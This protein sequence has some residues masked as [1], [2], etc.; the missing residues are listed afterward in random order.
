M[1]ALDQRAVR[2]QDEHDARRS[3]LLSARDGASGQEAGGYEREE[4]GKLDDADGATHMR[5]SQYSASFAAS[6]ERARRVRWNG[7]RCRGCDA[8]FQ[9]RTQGAPV[10]MRYGRD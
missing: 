5:F 4:P 8:R 9:A 6:L 1:T 7:A 3:A 2:R 10:S